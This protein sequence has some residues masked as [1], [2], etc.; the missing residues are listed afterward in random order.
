MRNSRISELELCIRMK[1]IEIV[2]VFGYVLG[3]DIES[4]CPHSTWKCS[5]SIVD[6]NPG[7]AK[8]F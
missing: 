7:V 5:K 2:A 8:S 3:E 4:P 1:I 6:I